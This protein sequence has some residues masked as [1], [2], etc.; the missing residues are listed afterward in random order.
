MGS[1]QAT[2]DRMLRQASRKIAQPRCQNLLDRARIVEAFELTQLSQLGD[3][4][5]WIFPGQPH[6]VCVLQG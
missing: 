1:K 6:D 5:P 3:R 2:K 4:L